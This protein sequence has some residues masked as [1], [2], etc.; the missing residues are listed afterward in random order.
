MPCCEEDGEFYECCQ[1]VIE[2]VRIVRDVRNF[3]VSRMY[4]LKTIVLELRAIHVLSGVSA[5]SN[6]A[7]CSHLRNVDRRMK[8][9]RGRIWLG[10]RCIWVHRGQDGQGGV[11]GCVHAGADLLVLRH[12]G[13]VWCG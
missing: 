5:R 13:C 4:L 10:G 3:A 11:A 8:G 7:Q 1:L 6:A 9:G 2:T 12:V